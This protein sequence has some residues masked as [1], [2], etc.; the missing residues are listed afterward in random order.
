MIKFPIFDTLYGLFKDEKEC[1]N[2]F[3]TQTDSRIKQQKKKAK[4]K[5]NSVISV[6]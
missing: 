2:L 1:F 5:K 3:N 4:I 6:H